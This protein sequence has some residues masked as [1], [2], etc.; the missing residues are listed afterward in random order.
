M[1]KNILVPVVF[2]EKHDTQ[3]SY[4]AARALADE[5]AS[6]TVLHVMEAIPSYAETQIPAEVLASSRHEVEKLL[7]RAARALPGSKAELVTGHAGR[8][9]VDYADKHDI[10]C[11]IV[12]SH[13]PGFENFFLGSTADRVVRH[14]NCAVHVIR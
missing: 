1:Y 11:I 14:A 4:L 2:D 6:F 3:A 13:R 12:A 5:G 8:A 7:T 10:D 9:I